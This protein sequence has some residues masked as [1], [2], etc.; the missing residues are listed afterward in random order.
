MIYL[1]NAGYLRFQF[2]FIYPELMN[3]SQSPSRRNI[4]YQTLTIALTLLFESL[5]ASLLILKTYFYTLGLHTGSTTVWSLPWS[6]LY[7]FINTIRYDT[8][9][10]SLSWSLNAKNEE[11]LIE[12]G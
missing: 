4:K 9:P 10:V 1:S 7:K 8:K 2:V 6:A 5:S 11:S 3:I 12:T